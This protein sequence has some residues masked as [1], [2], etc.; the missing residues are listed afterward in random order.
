MTWMEVTV[1]QETGS[2][3]IEQRSVILDRFG[4]PLD[5]IGG[6]KTCFDDRGQ[7]NRAVANCVRPR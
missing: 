1:Q 6:D 7:A 5:E 3:C 2:D 4:G